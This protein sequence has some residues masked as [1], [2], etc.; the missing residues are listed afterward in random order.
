MCLRSA[1]NHGA[2]W[3]KSTNFKGLVFVPKMQ[4][5]L[6]WDLKWKGKTQIN[7]QVASEWKIKMCG[8]L[9]PFW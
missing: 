2:L 7:V 9:T 1:G 5:L 8:V 3:A 6:L 4:K